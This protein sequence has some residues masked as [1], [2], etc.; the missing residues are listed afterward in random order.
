MAKLILSLV[1]I[2]LIV[3]FTYLLFRRVSSL[4]KSSL[5]EGFGSGHG[6]GHG[7]GGHGIGGHGIIGHGFGG[8]GIGGHGIGGHGIRGHGFGWN[9]VS[10]WYYGGSYDVNPLYI[11]EEEE[12]PLY[13]DE[14]GRP[15]I[16]RR[17]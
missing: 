13:Y 16:L 14:Y 15:L 12:E 7:F 4:S 17:I 10:P 5:N 11:Y 9:R 2:L 3:Y 1:L 8:H 6:G